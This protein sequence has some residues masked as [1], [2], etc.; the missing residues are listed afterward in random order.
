M[1]NFVI[2]NKR[3]FL[4]LMILNIILFFLI[5][6]LSFSQNIK[7]LKYKYS[8]SGNYS[9]SFSKI[10]SD[11]STINDKPICCK[12]IKEGKSTNNEFGIKFLYNPQ[13]FTQYTIETNFSYNNITLNEYESEDILVNGESYPGIFNNLLNINSNSISVNIGLDYNIYDAFFIGITSGLNYSYLINYNYTEKIIVPSDRG[14]FKDTKKRDRNQINGIFKDYFSPQLHLNLYYLLEL[15]SNSKYFI[16]P[17]IKFKYQYN[18]IDTGFEYNEYYLVFKLGIQY[19][20][21][22]KV[23]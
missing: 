6:H 1:Y 7:F 18:N 16:V 20:F 11:V 19:S 17:E 2:I 23:L 14:V 10:A 15:N 12:T 22:E 5:P 4:I 13:F 8:L 3:N 9:R 21:F